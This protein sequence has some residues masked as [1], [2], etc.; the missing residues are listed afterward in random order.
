MGL[1]YKT[2]QRFLDLGERVQLYLTHIGQ[3]YGRLKPP[4]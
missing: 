3:G 1:I 2:R 4:G